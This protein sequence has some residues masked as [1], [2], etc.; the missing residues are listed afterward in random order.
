MDSSTP[1]P[2]RP[3]RRGD[4][5]AVRSFEEIRATLDAQGRLDGVPF[6]PEMLPYCGQT[7]RVD[8]RM[9]RTC[10]EGFETLR[11]MQG[12]VLLDGLR[13]DGSAHE[14]CQR[15]CMMMWKEAWLS[16]AAEQAASVTRPPSD[17]DRA[18]D[19]PTRQGDRFYCQST[20]LGGATAPLPPGDL[21]Y[22]LDDLR[23]GEIRLRRL[24]NYVWLKAMGF[25]WRRLFGREYCQA[26]SGTGEQVDLPPL[27]LQPGELVEVRSLGEIQATL[28]ARGCHRGLT[29]EYEMRRFC[30][31]RMRVLGPVQ[32]IILENTGRKASLKN[33]VILAAATCEG[34]C[35]RNCPRANYFYWREIWLKRLGTPSRP[36]QSA[37]PRG[38][39]GQ[40]N[41]LISSLPHAGNGSV[42]GEVRAAR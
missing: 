41:E 9:D 7:F 20:E 8:R 4:L 31:R 39:A 23:I 40:E 28:D 1:R 15:R 42:V 21:R 24:L 14:G 17:P 33:T 37:S 36:G 34:I 13:C 12:T 38:Q 22:Y 3:Y 30:G 11:A 32:S 2:N 6:M 18:C 26:P 29:F 25:V 10:V 27:D 5:V 35:A 16:P 19:L